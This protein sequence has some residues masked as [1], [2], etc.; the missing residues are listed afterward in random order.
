MKV[1][2]IFFVFNKNT[3][4]SVKDSRVLG[5]SNWAFTDRN[6]SVMKKPPLV[7]CLSGRTL[8]LTKTKLSGVIQMQAVTS[9][10]TLWLEL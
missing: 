10:T 4:D 3:I 5:P 2:T 7:P 8:C 9:L 6:L 1:S